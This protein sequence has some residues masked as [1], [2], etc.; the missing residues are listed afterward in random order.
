LTGQQRFVYTFTLQSIPN[1]SD[2]YNAYEIVIQSAH[3]QRLST[4]YKKQLN[5]AH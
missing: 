5:V 1:K 3:E 4:E 2:N